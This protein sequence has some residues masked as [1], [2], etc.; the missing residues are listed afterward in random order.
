[1]L[2]VIPELLGGAPAAQSKAQAIHRA[3]GFSSD[4]SHHRNLSE[5]MQYLLLSAH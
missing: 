1:M 2:Q 3:G 4:T 5:A